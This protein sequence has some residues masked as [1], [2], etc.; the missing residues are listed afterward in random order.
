ML[1]Q[2]NKIT[3]AGLIVVILLAFFVSAPLVSLFFANELLGS[4]F[5]QP[6]VLSL[7]FW[8]DPYLRRVIYFSLLQAGL[9]TLLSVSLGLI[10]ARA[11]ARFGEFPFRRLILSLFGLPLVVPAIVAVLGIISVYGSQGWLPLG[12][13]LYGLNGILL[14]HLFF[15]LPL[16]VRL[17]LPAWQS[18]PQQHWRV[19]SQLGM[20]P[21]QQWKHLEWPALRE[22]LPGVTLLIFM[23]CLTSFA[24]V[25]SLGG[26]PK[27]TTLEVAIYQSLRFDFDPALAVILS[28]LQLGISILLALLAAKLTY[29]PDVEAVLTTVNSEIPQSSNK[30]ILAV[31]IGGATLF[32][33]SPLLAMLIEAIQGPLREVLIDTKLW[34]AAAF[35]L[36]IGICA[37]LISVSLGWILLSASALHAYSGNKRLAALF[38]FSGSVIYVVPPLVIG[39]G[40]FILLSQSINVFDW[41][42]PLVIMINGLMGLPFVIHTLGP[43][44]RQHTMRYQRLCAS[45]NLSSWQRFKQ[46]DL[47]LLRKP[48]GLSMALVTAMAMGDLGVIA[49]FGTPETA[50]LPL[51]LYQRLAAYQ[52]PQATVT[53]VFLLICC[54]LAFWLL[55]HFMG[56]KHSASNKKVKS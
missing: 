11:F 56:N 21:R 33:L 1:N 38:D 30:L 55:E 37:G 20:G 50:T 42:I 32:V 6:Q 7:A 19:S 41:A 18:I 47:P 24:V 13:K 52:I 9:S 2:A 54:L 39:T 23:L 28:L 31:L 8:N 26:G 51:L 10:V 35:S 45:L 16:T 17:L 14:A 53:A 40:L 29:K 12:S 44:M 22:A 27:S 5:S 34:R 25:L 36:M 15:N 43:A 49:L 46:I 48:V 4:Q 3:T